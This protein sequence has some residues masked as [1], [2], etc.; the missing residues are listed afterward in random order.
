[1]SLTARANLLL[2]LTALI[3]GLGFVAQRLGADHMGAMSF[4]A[5]RFA[6]G[7]ASLLPLIWW[8]ARQRRR[9]ATALAVYPEP[10]A[11]RVSAPAA[12][13]TRPPWLPGLVVG[14][15][16]FTAATLQQIGIADT[17]A[18]KAAFI[19]GLYLL[20]V[21]LL[22]LALGSRVSPAVWVGITL[23]LPG[24]WLLSV[25]GA[26]FS[27]IAT[28]D[29][30]VL[31]GAFFWAVH[32]LVIDRYIRTVD[33]LQLSAVQF[34]ACA[35]LS[36]GAALLVEPDPFGGMRPALTAILYSGLVAVGVAYTLQVVAQR[37][38][39]PSHAALLL[40]LETVFGALGGWLV[41]GE[42]MTGRMLLGA[43]LM[44]A[45][46]LV[47]LRGTESRETSSGGPARPRT[48]RRL[49]GGRTP[50]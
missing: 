35:L 40:S 8:L 17:T 38:A 1:V 3:W 4:N 27:T 13:P 5:V 10:P 18:G 34:A 2:V 45:G 47:S 28:G 50:G 33:A 26:G 41:L 21:P 14:L 39:K 30:L 24:L 46:I 42:V 36:A 25:T 9:R 6:I 29:L 23:A 43:S 20:I 11:G 19:T 44:L 16:L 22:G 49:P 12:L 32:I 48:R 31:A 15:V 7:A 37:D